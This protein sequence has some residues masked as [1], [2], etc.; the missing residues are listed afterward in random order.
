[1]LKEKIKRLESGEGERIKEEQKSDG[2][3]EKEGD[4]VLEDN[5]ES[6][7]RNEKGSSR[8]KSRRLA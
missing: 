2:I 6:M 3:M 8:R 7:E 4:Y 5:E 1:M